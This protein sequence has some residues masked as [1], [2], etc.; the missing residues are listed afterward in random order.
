MPF[1]P[2]NFRAA[3]VHSAQRRQSRERRHD[4][5]GARGGVEPRE[6]KQRLPAPGA[7]VAAGPFTSVVVS[8]A[9]TTTIP[10]NWYAEYKCVHCN[11]WQEDHADGVH[12]LFSPTEYTAPAPGEPTESRFTGPVTPSGSTANIYP[13][14]L[15]GWSVGYTVK[16]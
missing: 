2:N 14:T 13:V 1:R 12:C 15:T 11:A 5:R 3:A 7:P 10:V 4:P 16:I 8:S 9:A 6:T